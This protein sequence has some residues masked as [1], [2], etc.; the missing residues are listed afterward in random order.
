MLTKSSS[1]AAAP[2]PNIAG[3]GVADDQVGIVFAH[4][5]GRNQQDRAGQGSCLCQHVLCACPMNRKKQGAGFMR[6][7]GWRPRAG[8]I[9]GIPGQLLKFLAAS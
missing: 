7:F 9:T 2:A 4:G 8:L 1:S 3:C 6:R 5:Q